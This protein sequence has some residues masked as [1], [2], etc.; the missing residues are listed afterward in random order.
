M[1]HQTRETNLCKTSRR[2]DCL[3]GAFV[4]ACLLAGS[5]L[6]WGAVGERGRAPAP[7]SQSGAV[8][9]PRVKQ[10]P[11]WPSAPHLGSEAALAFNAP[12]GAEFFTKPIQQIEVGERVWAENPTGEEDLS[13][14][15]EVE[16]AT[17]RRLDLTIPDENDGRFDIGLLRPLSWIEETG[18]EVGSSVHLSM[19]ELGLD[20]PAEVV[21]VG[22]CPSIMPGS[23]RVV[24]GTFTHVRA[25]II[26]LHVAGL[27]KPIGVMENH[28]IY[29]LDHRKF[30]HAGDLGVGARVQTLD[31]NQANSWLVG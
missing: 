25:G 22:P 19:P 26:E 29:S 18:V 20:G 6:I 9:G 14:G 4:V 23:G 5:H 3:V 17:W 1:I 30:V 15:V 28:P 11:A 27:D 7:K 31:P 10:E 24:T 2:T 12:A 16:S 13:L 8:A 21:A